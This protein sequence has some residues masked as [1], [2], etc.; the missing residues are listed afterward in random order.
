M[1]HTVKLLDEIHRVV[2]PPGYGDKIARRVLRRGVLSIICL[3]WLSVLIA[4]VTGNSMLGYLIGI[5]V[6]VTP[7]AYLVTFGERG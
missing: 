4:L 5:A 1:G 3:S 2:K 7:M 6:A